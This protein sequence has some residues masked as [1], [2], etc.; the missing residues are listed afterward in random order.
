MSEPYTYI[1]RYLSEHDLP[2]RDIEYVYSYGGKNDPSW[3][4]AYKVVD[5]I[6]M[7]RG[8]YQQ[9]TMLRIYKLEEERT[10]GAPPDVVVDMNRHPLFA[11]DRVGVIN[12]LLKNP[13]ITPVAISIGGSYE[14][15]VSPDEYL[16]MNMPKPKPRDED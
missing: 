11:S 9:E 6:F 2:L 13:S 1:L 10:I 16:T 3:W 15:Y 12:W 7:F 4:S 8:G 14:K 5:R